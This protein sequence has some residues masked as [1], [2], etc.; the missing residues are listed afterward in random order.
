MKAEY[1]ANEFRRYATY[2]RN[3]K[4]MGK[5]NWWEAP[6]LIKIAGVPMLKTWTG[7]K[8]LCVKREDLWADYRSIVI[9]NPVKNQADGIL[10]KSWY[11]T[12]VNT[13]KK[14]PLLKQN[15]SIMDY[16][17]PEKRV[18]LAVDEWGMWVDN[19]PGTNPAFLYQQNTMRSAMSAAL[20]LHIFQKYPDRI[21]L[22]N[23]RRL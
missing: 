2:V 12:A 8:L 1:Y 21:R 11:Q 7:P 14:E 19:E 17:D 16:Y 18:L 15:M 13:Y 9:L 5:T 3:Y 20:M 23:L 10:E 6:P 22:C 4:D